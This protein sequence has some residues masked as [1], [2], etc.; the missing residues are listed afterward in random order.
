MV[1]DI[2]YKTGSYES[3]GVKEAINLWIS[4][5]FTDGH[6]LVFKQQA[7]MLNLHMLYIVKLFEKHLYALT[8]GI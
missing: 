8:D 3:T 4:I 1:I 6:L 2:F 5:M 7:I